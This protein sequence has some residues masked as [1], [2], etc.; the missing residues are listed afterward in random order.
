M[1]GTTIAGIAGHARRTPDGLVAAVFLSFLAT[2]GIFYVN[3][4]PA[5]VSGL[6]SG[7]GFSQ[8]EAGFVGSANLYGAAL[9]ALTIV[10]LIARVAWRKAS[11]ALLAGLVAID[12][13][14]MA[15]HVPWVM[16]P[17]RALHGFVGGMLVGVAFAVIA[18]TKSPDRVFGVLLFVQFGLGGLGVMTLP[19]LVPVFGTGVLFAALIAFSA[20]TLAMLPFLGP[21]SPRPAAAAVAVN[22]GSA[23]WPRFVLALLAIFLFQASNM[24]LFAYIIELGS[25]AG[26]PREFISTSV[27]A[28]TWVGVAGCLLVIVLA[29]RYGRA[30]P[31][32]IGLAATLVGI[33]VLHYSADKIVFVLA[34]CMTGITWS[35]VMPY[36][37]GLASAFDRSGRA[38]AL[39]GFASKMGLAS[40]PLL[41]ALILRGDDYGFLI[42]LSCLGI[43]ACAAAALVPARTVDQAT[44]VPG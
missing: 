21:Y 17:L 24:G 41:G 30:L 5:L 7:L 4:M 43:I 44:R 36:L 22:T 23:S 19:R 2:A 10:L 1:T 27:G 16:I 31:L 12:A 26:L 37:L 33:W 14:S 20:V 9:G 39:G 11:I 34:N 13:I 25:A 35:L 18:R 40:G 29:T 15:V 28:A 32:A 38:A 42:N 3:I 6:I 8:R